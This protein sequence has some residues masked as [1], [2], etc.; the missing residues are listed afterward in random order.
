MKEHIDYIIEYLKKQPFVD[1]CITGS[2]MLDEYWD[3]MDVDLF[4]YSEKS[5][6]AILWNLYYNEDFLILD[7]AEQWKFEQYVTKDNGKSPFGVTSLK[8]V[9][10]TCIPVNIIYK[11]YCSS[12]FD[13]LAT[14]DMNIIAKGYDIKTGQILDLSGDSFKTK[15]AN[16]NSWNSNYY[17][18][19]LWQISRVLRQL[20]RCIKYYK[21]GYNTDAVVLKYIELIDIIQNYQN[22]FDSPTF[23]EKLKIRKANTKLIK[24]ILIVWLNTHEITDKEIELMKTKIKEI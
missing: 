10:N 22:I 12:I 17:D 15:I 18:P 21:R 11:R 6:Q 19:S 2:C 5:F 20:E 7:K 4:L 8:F 16:P 24:Q 1:G 23:N 9:Y 3:G 14:F 13:I